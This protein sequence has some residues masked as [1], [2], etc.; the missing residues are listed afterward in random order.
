M[1][2][3]G[4][5]AAV[6]AC[7]LRAGCRLRS[8]ERSG[9]IGGRDLVGFWGRIGSFH[10]HRVVVLGLDVILVGQFSGLL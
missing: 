6:A 3:L 9:V 8:G 7:H 10:H 5:A 1:V 2:D 4:L